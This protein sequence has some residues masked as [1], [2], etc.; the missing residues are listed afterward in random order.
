MEENKKKSNLGIIICLIIIIVLAGLLVFMWNYYNNFEKTINK[1]TITSEEFKKYIEA[2][3]FN[4][5]NAEEYLENNSYTG[6]LKDGL[7]SGY[8]TN[9]NDENEYRINFYELK[10]E[11]HTFYLYYDAILSTEKNNT[12][13]FLEAK[14]E[15]GNY[16]KYAALTNG[17][18]EVI[19]KI[20]NTLI[21][22]QIDANKRDELDSIL[23]ELGY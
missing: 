9:K 20:D 1:S 12:G 6:Y 11:N 21:Y 7:K 10:D 8:I 14:E 5:Y 16:Y 18:Y 17:Y 23:N 2:K 19:I 4:I 13:E 22:G 3:G 15:N